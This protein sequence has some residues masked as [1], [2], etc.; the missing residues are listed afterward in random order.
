MLTHIV[1]DVDGTLTD[2]GVYYDARANELKKFSTKDGVGFHIARA[3]TP[4]QA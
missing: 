4:R 2:S 1:L 3:A